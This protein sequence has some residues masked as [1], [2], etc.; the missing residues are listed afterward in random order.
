MKKITTDIKHLS[1]VSDAV[2]VTKN[3]Q[4]Q[5]GNLSFIIYFNKK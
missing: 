4:H 3:A 5:R 2:A 1:T